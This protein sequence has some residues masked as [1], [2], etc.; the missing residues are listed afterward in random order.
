MQCSLCYVQWIE[1]VRGVKADLLA[2]NVG[3]QYNRRCACGVSAG[4]HKPDDPSHFIFD[5]LI[6]IGW[7]CAVPEAERKRYIPEWN[8]YIE[9]YGRC[10]S[11]GRFTT[12]R[13]FQYLIDVSEFIDKK[14]VCYFQIRIALRYFLFFCSI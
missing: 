5:F 10:C 6:R 12:P 9:P 7:I 13:G 2:K 3:C 4:P 14:C 1:K 8:R 11:E